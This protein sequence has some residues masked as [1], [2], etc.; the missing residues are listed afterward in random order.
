[1]KRNLT[2]RMGTT[3][4]TTT[5][6]NVIT[7]KRHLGRTTWM[8]TT[9]NDIMTGNVLSYILRR[10]SFQGAN[11]TRMPLSFLGQILLRLCSFLG[12]VHLRP[13]LH[14]LWQGPSPPRLYRF[15]GRGLLPRF[16]SLDST[17]ALAPY[18]LLSRAMI[19]LYLSFSP[20]ANSLRF[21]CYLPGPSSVPSAV[22]LTDGDR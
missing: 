14:P 22:L 9:M 12:L 2:I 4:M 1:M 19:G 3:S 21:H 15:L 11:M 20:G 8:T 13:L 7:P 18:L 6:T 10:C 17:S 5:P 16:P